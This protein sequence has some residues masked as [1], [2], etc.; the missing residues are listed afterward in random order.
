VKARFDTAWTKPSARRFVG[1]LIAVIWTSTALQPCLMAAAPE[2]PAGHANHSGATGYAV[3]APATPNCEHCAPSSDGPEHFKVPGASACAGDDQGAWLS[4]TRLQ[5][6]EKFYRL[7]KPA[8]FAQS[9]VSAARKPV[10]AIARH[11]YLPPGAAGPAL[12]DLFRS[13]LK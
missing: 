2:S 13:Y 5:D 1:L 10:L 9:P 3:K 6:A 4:Q 8:V 12:I 7:P 11:S